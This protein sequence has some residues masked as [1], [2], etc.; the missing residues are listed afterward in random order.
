MNRFLLIC[1]L[2]SCASASL[3]AQKRSRD[4]DSLE[5]YFDE[6]KYLKALDYSKRQYANYKRHDNVP[7]MVSVA[8][9]Q[10]R[11]YF[12]LGDSRK[13]TETLY[14]ALQLAEDHDDLKSKA[15][16]LTYMGS[17]L[18][19]RLDYVTAKKRFHESLSIAKRIGNDSLQALSTQSLFAV[20]LRTDGDSV[21]YYLK[22]ADQMYRQRNTHEAYYKAYSNS[23]GYYMHIGDAK[24][25]ETYSD[26]MLAEA[27]RT[28][29]KRTLF[30]ALTNRAVVFYNKKDFKSAK[31]LYDELFQL[32]HDTL[33][34]DIGD[35]YY[36]Y[37]GIL[38]G[39]GD[40][41]KAYEYSE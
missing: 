20:S 26:S 27:R 30:S 11:I 5:I 18:C 38:N 23:F 24:L 34:S 35:S 6:S 15:V 28:K 33:S 10:S 21:V 17:L 9:V 31:V 19:D 22:K 4:R 3:H 1:F 41:K 32:Q 36:T 25:A 2:L 29:S 7:K 37:A 16:V 13:A 39:L 12:R 40:Y 14:D 8:A